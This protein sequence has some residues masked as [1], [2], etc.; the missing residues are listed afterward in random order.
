MLLMI[1]IDQ[2]LLERFQKRI[3]KNKSRTIL[4]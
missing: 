1:S 2:K 4:N 3:A